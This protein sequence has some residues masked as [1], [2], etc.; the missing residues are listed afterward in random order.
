MDALI[1]A[2]AVE[3]GLPVITQDD[4]DTAEWQKPTLPFPSSWYDRHPDVWPFPC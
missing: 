3:H 2:T 4:D 1:A